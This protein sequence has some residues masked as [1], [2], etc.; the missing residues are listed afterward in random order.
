M[1]GSSERVANNQWQM[2]AAASSRTGWHRRLLLSKCIEERERIFAPSVSSIAECL[3]CLPLLLE[4]DYNIVV[5]IC[6]RVL[7]LHRVVEVSL[8]INISDSILSLLFCSTSKGE[9]LFHLRPGQ[10][11]TMPKGERS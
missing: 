8:I 6:V 4:S 2:A 9:K 7:L 1:I 3:I 11:L 10:L 5:G